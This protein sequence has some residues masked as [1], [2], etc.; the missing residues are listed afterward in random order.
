MTAMRYERLAAAYAIVVGAAM[1]GLWVELVWSGGLARLGAG[2][3]ELALH[4]AAEA[5]T[6][7]ALV[8][9]GVAIL[10]DRRWGLRLLPVALGM[11]LYAAVDAGGFYAPLVDGPLAVLLALVIAAT[12]LALA[13]FVRGDLLAADEE[14]PRPATRYARGD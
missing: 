8:A 2:G 11:L 9:T 3:P 1:V 7:L 10:T 13:A 6:V 12:A 4:L 5:A 14:A